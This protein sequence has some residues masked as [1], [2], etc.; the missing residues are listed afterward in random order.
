MD[1]RTSFGRVSQVLFDGKWRTVKAGSFRIRSFDFSETIPTHG[2]SR[3]GVAFAQWED[4]AG[5]SWGCPVATLQGIRI[6]S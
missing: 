4:E 5:T 2:G 6:E 3:D 1:D